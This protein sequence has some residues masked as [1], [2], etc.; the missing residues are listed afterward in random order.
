MVDEKAETSIYD[1]ADQFIGLANELANK[2]N[3]VGKIGTALRFAAA[4]YNAFEAS[5]KS[6]D[7]ASEKDSA[8]E[9]FTNEY[10]T[11]LDDNIEDHIVNPVVTDESSKQ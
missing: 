2:E 4:R 3:D 7:L 5:I 6:A 10:K 8:M 9:W 11:M 1:L